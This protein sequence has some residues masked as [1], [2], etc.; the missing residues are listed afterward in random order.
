MESGGVLDITREMLINKPPFYTSN[1]S[2]TNS[3]KMWLFFLISLAAAFNNPAGVEIWCG[4]A[5]QSTYASSNS[6]CWD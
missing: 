1:T 4:K 6:T 2:P 5:Y 3:L